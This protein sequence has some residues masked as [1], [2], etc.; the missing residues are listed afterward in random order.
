MP[1]AGVTVTRG[2]AAA[3]PRRGGRPDPAGRDTGAV[4]IV[5]GPGV[6]RSGQRLSSPRYFAN[7]S[8]PSMLR[9]PLMPSL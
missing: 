4:R 5:H 1:P 2:L 7:F 6:L 3:L 9:G 8:R